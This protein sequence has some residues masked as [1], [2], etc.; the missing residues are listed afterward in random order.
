M[1]EVFR[2]IDRLKITGRGIVYTVEIPKGFTVRV[3]IF[4]LIYVG[5]DSKSKELRCLGVFL[6]EN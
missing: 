5:I 1:S 3:G 6:M 2:I 4:C